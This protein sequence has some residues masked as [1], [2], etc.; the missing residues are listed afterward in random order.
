MYL[1]QKVRIE[2]FLGFKLVFIMYFFFILESRDSKII[3]NYFHIIIIIQEINHCLKNC[4]PFYLHYHQKILIGKETLPKNFQIENVRSLKSWYF[5][6][7]R[8]NQEIKQYQ[9]SIKRWIKKLI[10]IIN[11]LNNKLSVRDK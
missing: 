4:E 9:N 11:E 10:K 1:G 8:K 5:N 3:F 7:Y 6:T 2:L